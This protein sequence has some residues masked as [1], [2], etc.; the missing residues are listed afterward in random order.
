MIF[1]G[2]LRGV[3][4]LQSQ[5]D[6]PSASENTQIPGRLAICAELTFTN[7]PT[8]QVLVFKATNVIHLP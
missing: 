5:W 2:D 4:A 8:D 1:A 7:H 3:T 6:L